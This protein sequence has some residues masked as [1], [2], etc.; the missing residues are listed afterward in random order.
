[1]IRKQIYLAPAQDR[2]VKALAAVRGSTESE[3]IRGAIDCLPDAQGSV[4]EQLA[5]AG[6]LAPKQFDPDLP[7]GEELRQLEAE[8]YEWLDSLPGP[9][10]LSEAVI[11]DR[12]G[13]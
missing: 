3:V 10:G 7:T 4:V 2:K 13:R 5:A 6:L 11:E 12:E 9:L 1:M 8:L